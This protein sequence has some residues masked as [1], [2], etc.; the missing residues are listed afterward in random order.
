MDAP[1]CHP[2][3]NVSRMES[4]RMADSTRMANSLPTDRAHASLAISVFDE[5]EVIRLTSIVDEAWRDQ[6]HEEIQIQGQ[7]DV[8]RND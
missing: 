3:Q 8:E 1:D 7:I 5:A 6:K 2:I 4:L